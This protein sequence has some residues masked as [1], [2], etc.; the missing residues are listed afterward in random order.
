[1]LT[2]K[3]QY[4]LFA[5]TYDW[6]SGGQ[7][8][9]ADKSLL[10][11]YCSNLVRAWDTEDQTLTYI[12]QQYDMNHNNQPNFNHSINVIANDGEQRMVIDPDGGQVILNGVRTLTYR[13][14]GKAN[15]IVDS[16]EIDLSADA[17]TQQE[18]SILNL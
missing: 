9:S 15:Q 12:N 17:F 7:L 5:R 18:I 1:M 13:V 8:T 3:S 4:S 10:R 2:E 6:E 11:F 16:G 14:L